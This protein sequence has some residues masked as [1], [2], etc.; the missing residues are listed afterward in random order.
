MTQIMILITLINGKKGLMVTLWLKA[1]KILEISVSVSVWRSW[2]VYKLEEPPP[3]QSVP[4]P[5]LKAVI[6]NKNVKN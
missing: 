5:P 4:T 6:E 2:Y 3:T 1:V